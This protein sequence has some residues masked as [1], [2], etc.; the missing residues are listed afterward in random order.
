MT[1]A[2]HP[3]AWQ[4]LSVY[5][6]TFQRQEF[7]ISAPQKSQGTGN[8]DITLKLEDVGDIEDKDK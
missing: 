2:M 4:T 3:S 5:R 1:H 8:R 6:M 7:W